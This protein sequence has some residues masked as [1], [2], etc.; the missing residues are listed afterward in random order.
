MLT[1]HLARRSLTN[2][3]LTSGLTL[4]SIALSVALLVGV[5]NVRTGMRESFSNT[6]SRTDLIVGPR[7][8]TLQLLLYSVFGMGSPTGNLSHES[9]EYWAEH[10]AVEWT[11]PYALGDSHRGFR[12]IGTDTTFYAR[13]RY[14]GGQELA[15]AEGEV[16]T[17]LYDLAL[18]ADVATELGY[19]LGDSVAVT[20]GMGGFMDHGDKP[21][22]VRAILAKTFTPVDRAIY[23]TLG[24]LAA[25]HLGWESGAPPRP[26]QEI[27]AHEAEEM[28]AHGEL[29]LGQITSFFVGV[30]SRQAV[31][32][33][34]RDI[35]TWSGEPMTA[36]IPGLALAELWRGIGFAENGLQV[37]TLFVVIVG[38]LGMVV[39]LYTS[40]DARRREMAILRAIGAGPGRIVTLLVLESGLLATGGAVVGLGLVYG[41]LVALQPWVEA[42]FGL[43]LPI[44]PPGATQL[45]YVG[46]VI[47]IGFVIGL[48]PALKAYRTALHD[49][50][51]VKV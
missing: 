48:V 26:G 16:P 21:F 30:R 50:L 8:G 25:V 43:Y 47:A 7:T 6:I 28:H 3:R 12:V 2:R 14:R 20:H 9:Y 36:V 31:L 19:A 13:Y 45:A 18:G 17:A 35:N 38:L 41:L 34:Q 23:T 22:V 4:A 42:Q 11:I 33:L 10:P 5:E 40:L 39:S 49:G 29:E 15:L 1:L 32:Q 44:D 46:A 37:V 51:A 27:A 24:G